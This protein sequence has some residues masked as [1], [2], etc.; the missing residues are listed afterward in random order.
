MPVAGARSAAARPIVEI[1]C[2]L[3]YTTPIYVW[4]LVTRIVRDVS[5]PYQ[6][7]PPTQ[8]PAEAS[9]AK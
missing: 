4:M 8:C 6:F 7:I 5:P 9:I 3:L 2:D 1:A